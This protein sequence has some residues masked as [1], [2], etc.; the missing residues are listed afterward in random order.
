MFE[1]DKINVVLQ[2]ILLMPT[3]DGKYRKSSK[4]YTDEQT[5]QILDKLREDS[6]ELFSESVRASSMVNYP[7]HKS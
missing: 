3:E 5:R 1:D 4:V 6:I 2:V 7:L